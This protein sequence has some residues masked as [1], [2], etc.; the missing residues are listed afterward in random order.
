MR[1][2]LLY[3]VVCQRQRCIS[4]TCSQQ[5]TQERCH[6]SVQMLMCS[7]TTQTCWKL[8]SVAELHWDDETVGLL[9]TAVL[10]VAE[11]RDDVALHL[12][13]E[14]V[15]CCPIDWRSWLRL[16]ANVRW[17]HIKVEVMVHVGIVQLCWNPIQ[18][19]SSNT[20]R[21]GLYRSKRTGSVLPSNT[22][23]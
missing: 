2:E 7:C 4:L 21:V 5:G 8:T 14:S 10:L 13:V 20:Q 1:L 19:G 17:V 23:L 16:R 18:H 6:F 9:V 11:V 22:L 15:K 3:M 12:V